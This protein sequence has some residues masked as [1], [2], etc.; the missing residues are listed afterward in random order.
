MELLDRKDFVLALLL[1]LVAGWVDAVGFLQLG[2]FFVSFMSGNSTRLGV[3]VGSGFWREAGLAAGLIATFVG[4]VAF[5]NLIGDRAGDRY[6]RSVLLLTESALL[7]VAG[8]FHM[9]GSPG[10][11]TVPMVLAMGIANSVLHTNGEVRFGV[12]YVTGALVMVGQRIAAAANGGARE[13]WKPYAAIWLA[14]VCGAAIGASAYP[15]IGGRA[16]WGPALLLLAIALLP[17][18]ALR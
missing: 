16:L 9:M 2:G 8:T 17:R 10:G 18:R 14:L 13:A 6:R 4:G 3:G 5:G 11:A 1:A 12:T 7:T 15:V